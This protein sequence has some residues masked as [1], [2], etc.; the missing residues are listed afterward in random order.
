MKSHLSILWTAIGSFSHVL[1][2]NI[3]PKCFATL[4]GCT[5]SVVKNPCSQ[6]LEAWG[7]K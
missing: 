1:S 3:A 5:R 2:V 6:A 4:G 7:K